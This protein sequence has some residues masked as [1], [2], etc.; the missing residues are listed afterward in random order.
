M[1]F[2]FNKTTDILTKLIG[3]RSDRHRII[4][5]NIANIDTPGYTARDLKFKMVMA[6]VTDNRLTKTHEK[7]LPSGKSESLKMEI[8]VIDSG[9]KVDL[10]NEMVNLAENH[11]R[12]NL[13]IE[14]LSRKF[15]SINN[16]IKEV[17]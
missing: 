15:R 13:S 2:L 17:R 1:E 9:E 4:S 14:F 16:I 6:E 3:F 10:D 8:E 5:S 11:L 7:H 12:H